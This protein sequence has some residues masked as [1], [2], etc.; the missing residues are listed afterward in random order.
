MLLQDTCMPPRLQ[1]SAG[2]AVLCIPLR[3]VLPRAPIASYYPPITKLPVVLSGSL[4]A[5]ALNLCVYHGAELAE[6]PFMPYNM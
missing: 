3:K 6:D 2:V 1:V 5:M 4:A